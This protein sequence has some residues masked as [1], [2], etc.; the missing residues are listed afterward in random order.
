MPIS[1]MIFQH[2]NPIFIVFVTPIIIGIFAALNKKGKEPSS[3]RKIG[4][5]MILAATGFVVMLISSLDLASPEMLNNL[6]APGDMRITPYTLVGVYFILTIA[7]LFLSPMGLS[8]VSKVA[9]P[10]MK[11]TMQAGWLCATAIGN[12]LLPIGSYLWGRIE[13]WQ[14]W[15]FFVVC[16]LLSAGFIFG[17]MKRLEKVTNNS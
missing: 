7:E 14:L 12:L 15:G 4:I 2:F 6:G 11:G 13:L 10:K 3:P 8:F 16:C 17:V 1:P 5:G 9:P